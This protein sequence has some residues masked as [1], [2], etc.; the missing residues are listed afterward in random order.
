MD[1][2]KSVVRQLSV[3]EVQAGGPEVHAAQAESFDRLA[4]KL[5]EG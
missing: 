3:V 2:T 1:S 5:R 4:A